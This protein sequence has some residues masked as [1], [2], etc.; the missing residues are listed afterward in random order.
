MNGKDSGNFV[1]AKGKKITFYTL[2]CRLNQAETALLEESF[3]QRG[4]TI[5]PFGKEADLCVVNSCTVTENGDADCRKTVRRFLRKNPDGDVT[6]IGCYSQVAAEEVSKIPGVGLVVGNRK[7]MKLADIIDNTPPDKNSPLIFNEPLKGKKP[8]SIDIKNP[9]PRTVRANLKIQDGCDFFCSYCVI[10]FARGRAQ[11]RDI[12]DLLRE[13]R[14][15][16]DNGYRE[17]VLSGINLGTYRFKEHDFLSVIREMEKIEGISRIRI[18]SIE[19]TTTDEKFLHYMAESEKL[20]R[21]LHLPLQSGSNAILHSMKRKYTAEQFS[22]YLEKAFTLVPDIAI[23]TDVIAG[24]PGET[25]EMFRQSYEFLQ[26]YP[27]AYFH[28]FSYSE[29]AL[30]KAAQLPDKIN[31]KTIRER[32]KKLRELSIQK[33][34]GYYRRFAGETV[35]VLFEQK[36]KGYWIGHDEHFITV[37]VKENTNLKN[38]CRKVKITDIEDELA[39]GEIV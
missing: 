20:C 7:K 18:S 36:K 25:E 28:V 34:N 14:E 22:D 29:R 19:P 1:E 32:S 15:L 5:V 26:R 9:A 27:F 31:P 16:A 8:F 13:A 11:S 2:G 4:Y 3:R 17:I 38:S 33:R 24:F 12:N 39:I 35:S 30:T 21:Y 6:V 23:G 10:P 37:A